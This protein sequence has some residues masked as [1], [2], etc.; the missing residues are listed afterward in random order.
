MTHT[1]L[2]PDFGGF[3]IRTRAEA[4]TMT[5]P[6]CTTIPP[7]AQHQPDTRMN[8]RDFAARASAY[9]PPAGHHF[10]LQG[11]ALR[12]TIAGR[13]TLLVITGDVKRDHLSRHGGRPEPGLRE[14]RPD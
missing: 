10:V 5:S 4:G 11:R 2:S 8:V 12:I 3:V 1:E 9:L 7:P 14:S 13:P 6:G